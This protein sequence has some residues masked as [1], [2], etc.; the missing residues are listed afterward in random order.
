MN[1]SHCGRTSR[2]RRSRSSIKPRHPVMTFLRKLTLALAIPAVMVIGA[3][4]TVALGAYLLETRLASYFEREDAWAGSVG[5]MLAQ[6][7][8][9][10]QALRNVV[11]DPANR[12][13]YENLDA[14]R[15]EYENA[16]A[17]AERAAAGSQRAALE[18][19]D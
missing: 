3:G 14:A 2:E 19:I 8:Q 11:L 16:R 15:V 5:D 4:G 10:G 17:R 12:R 18:R 6:G 1:G 13:A 9:M 7:L